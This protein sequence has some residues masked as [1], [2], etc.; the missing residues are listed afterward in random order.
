MDNCWICSNIADSEEHKFKASDLKRFHGKKMNAF[1]IS[2]EVIELN[3][4]KDKNLK[5]P[6]VICTNCN[7]N[8]TRPHDD[9]YDKFVIY[10]FEN[11]EQILKNQVINFEEIYGKNWELEKVNLYRY[12]SKHAGC[13]IVTSNIKADLKNLSEFIKGNRQVTD[14]LVKFE[15]K[16]GVQAIM[17]AFNMANKYNHLYNSE[18]VCWN[19]HIA[20]KFG[21]WLTNNYMSTNW[22]FGTNINTNSKNIF[23][24][25]YETILLTDQHFFEINEQEDDAKFSR[26]KFIDQYII[27]FENSYNKTTELKVE[28]FENLILANNTAHN[29]Y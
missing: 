11:H 13:K 27:G 21:G 17:H 23:K 5:F 12:Y 1:Y 24:N 7:N 10:C 28:Y 29:N 9:A 20:P 22:V 6:K 26:L 18:T 15:K 4:Y 16:A 25:K 3:S 2:K 14:F 19:I 8:L